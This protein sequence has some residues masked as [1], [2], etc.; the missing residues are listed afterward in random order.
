VPLPAQ[1]GA[2][3]LTDAHSASL[4]QARQTFAAQIG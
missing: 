4:A 1:S 3:A 2:P